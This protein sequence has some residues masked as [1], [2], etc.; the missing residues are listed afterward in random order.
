[1]V[2]CCDPGGPTARAGWGG[3]TRTSEWRLE[4][5]LEIRDEF[6]GFPEHSRTRDFSACELPQVPAYASRDR[7]MNRRLKPGTM[8]GS[9]NIRVS[10][11][12]RRSSPK[13]DL[14]QLVHY[15]ADY[16]RNWNGP[17]FSNGKTSR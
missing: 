16:H 6:L 7:P 11:I 3:R 1:V 2:N 15:R 10:G 14:H 9:G 8:C 4:K 17:T 13:G 5:S 12:L